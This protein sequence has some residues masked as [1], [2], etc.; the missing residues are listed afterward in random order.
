MYIVSHSVAMKSAGVQP[1]GSREFET[2]TDKRRQL[3]ILYP[4]S[5]NPLSKEIKTNK[6]NVFPLSWSPNILLI[7]VLTLLF[8]LVLA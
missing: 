8:F 6:I 7:S 2:G 5:I 4:N 1:S 3:R